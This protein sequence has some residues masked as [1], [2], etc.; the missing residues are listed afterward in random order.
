M[1]SET[2]VYIESNSEIEPPEPPTEVT[3]PAST[4]SPAGIF[5]KANILE[6]WKVNAGRF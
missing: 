4:S 1:V 3:D 2:I 5:Y 6:W